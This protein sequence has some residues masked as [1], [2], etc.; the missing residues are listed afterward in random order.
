[1]ALLFNRSANKS[2]KLTPTRTDFSSKA[3]AAQ[4]SSPLCFFALCLLT[5]LR[6]ALQYTHD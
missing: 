1:L 6:T 4:L 3:A 5:L 2:P